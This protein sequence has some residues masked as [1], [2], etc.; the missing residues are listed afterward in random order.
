MEDDR[1]IGAPVSPGG[2]NSA[3]EVSSD[4]SENT[5]LLKS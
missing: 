3:G 2:F 4:I 1:S 5:L